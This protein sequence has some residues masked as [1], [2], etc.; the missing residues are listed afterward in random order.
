MEQHIRRRGALV[1]VLHYPRIIED[2]EGRQWAFRV[3]GG[4]KSTS[5]PKWGI[6]YVSEEGRT[7]Y[8][9]TPDRPDLDAYSDDDLVAIVSS[10]TERR[11]SSNP[12]N[13]EIP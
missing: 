11:N 12:L 2:G 13:R 8:R 1:N 7:G 3:M 4:S 6:A 9:S 10:W 5:P